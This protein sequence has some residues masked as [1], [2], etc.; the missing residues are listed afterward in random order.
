MALHYKSCLWKNNQNY[1]LL[2][3]QTRLR[4]CKGKY[5]S[6][7]CVHVQVQVNGVTSF[8][9]KYLEFHPPNM[10]GVGYSANV[11]QQAAI[12]QLGVGSQVNIYMPSWTTPMPVCTTS[13]SEHRTVFLGFLLAPT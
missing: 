9:V 4:N 3:L 7:K 10:T 11:R 6:L 1:V 13:F 8:A 5:V 2:Q 12:L